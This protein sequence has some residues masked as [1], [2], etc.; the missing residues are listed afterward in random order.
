MNKYWEIVR[1]TDG[2][3]ALQ[4]SEDNEDPLVRIEFSESAE[5][6]LKDQLSEV[7]Q[8]MIGA[9]VQA[10]NFIED[11]SFEEPENLEDETVH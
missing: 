7:A 4:S 10:A 11:S 1:L 6:L 5:N 2:S 9:G 3:F 8:A